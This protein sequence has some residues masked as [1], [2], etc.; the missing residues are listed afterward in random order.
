MLLVACPATNS[1][2]SARP[3][4]CVINTYTTRC[5]ASLMP[6]AKKRLRREMA[7]ILM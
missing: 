5:A 3:E 7:L 4:H 6:V 2:S 1:K